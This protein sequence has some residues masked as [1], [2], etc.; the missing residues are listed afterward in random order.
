ML[1]FFKL[2]DFK[3]NIYVGLYSVLIYII[4]IF[5]L[6]ELVLIIVKGFFEML[7]GIVYGFFFGV[8]LW[9]FLFKDNVSL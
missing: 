8:F 3:I 7:L 9:Y 6:G 1:I 2:V 4:F 5:V